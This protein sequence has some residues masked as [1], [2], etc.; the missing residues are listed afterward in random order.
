MP[1]SIFSRLKV[2]W[3]VFR[4]GQEE[5]QIPKGPGYSFPQNKFRFLYGTEESIISP[6]YNQLGIDVSAIPIRHVRLDENGR[7]LEVIN[8]G[9]NNCLSLE[10][11]ID[12]T[13]RAF[14]QDAVMS[15]CDD[16]SVALVPVDTSYNPMDSGSYDILTIRT[17]KI[18]QWF[19]EQVRINLYNQIT[20]NRQ[21]ITLPKN[22]VAIIENPFYSIM[23]QPNSIL[24][25]LIA[26]L[27]LLDAVD[28]QSG[29]GK[30]DVIV[31]VPYVV[32]SK[33]LQE[34]AEQRKVDIESQLANSKYGIAYIDGT[35]KVTQLNRPAE[36]QLMKQVEYLTDMLF[37]Q[38]GL[39]KEIFDGTA[40]EEVMINYYNRTIEPFLSA[41]SDGMKRVFLTKTGRSQGQSIMFI[42][43]PFRLVPVNT[44][45]DIADKFTRNE[46]MSSNELRSI[47]G[48][49]PSK[50]EG[51][52]EL[53]NKNLNE[54]N[55]EKPDPNQLKKTEPISQNGRKNSYAE[56]EV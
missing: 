2:A 55:P 34:R 1:D 23:N 13:G 18:I 33:T 24:K 41:L 30:L 29:S 16:G 7:F 42:R 40:K 50:E 38:L 46:I 54:A 15:M 52:D 9:L 25:R 19:P 49:K 44:L 36:N 8:S 56:K 27:N 31:Q 6:I 51:A 48:L 43:D 5:W 3:N 39:T 10:A 47:V 17:G 14:I 32:K 37:S 45:A 28:N 35:E 4:N 53:R 11:N 26:K 22:M 21:E 20:G 12:Q